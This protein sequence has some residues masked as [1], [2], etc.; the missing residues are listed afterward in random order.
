[1]CVARALLLLLL[2]SLPALGQENGRAPLVGVLL[3]NEA[4]NPGPAVPLLRQGLA[5]SGYVE[6]RN[7]R[8]DF[9]FAEGHA[10]RFPELAEALAEEKAA[11]I[12]ALRDAA[13]RAAQQAT[14]TIPIVAVADDLVA[15]GLIQSMAAAPSG[16]TT[17]ISIPATELD[18][19]K[20]ELL[21]QI[22]PNARRF[23]LLR[24]LASSTEARLDAIS[25]MARTLGI[26]LQ[27][28]DVKSP[29]DFATAFASFREGGAEALDILAS[30]LLA[31]FQR[32]LGRLSL[33]DKLPAIC[34]F[35]EMAEAGCLA[36]Y[37]VKRPEMYAMVAAYAD[38]MLKGANPGTMVAQQ[39]SAIELVI[40]LKAAHKIGIEI[41]SAVLARADEVIE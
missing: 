39:P 15:S 37:G 1:M 19:K 23:A 14:R 20:L 11:V 5:G 22:M 31:N 9:R 18:A 30:P 29:A 32:E 26:E 24:D 12:V 3:V 33:E 27:T 6:G 35:R 25:E 41:P 28:V 38:K 13:T 17:G 40:N 2:I 10:E 7:L 8:L 34:Q 21:K 36:S 16:N 4:A